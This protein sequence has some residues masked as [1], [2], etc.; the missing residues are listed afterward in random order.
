VLYELFYQAVQN[1][2]LVLLSGCD[3][4]GSIEKELG[5]PIGVDQADQFV[6]C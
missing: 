5:G 6:A 3:L 4:Q 1:G 2:A